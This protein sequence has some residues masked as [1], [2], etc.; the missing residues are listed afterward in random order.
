MANT[1]ASDVKFDFGA[2]EQAAVNAY[3]KVFPYWSDVAAA[4][5]CRDHG[6]IGDTDNHFLSSHDRGYRRDVTA[7][8]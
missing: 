7:G 4:A 1:D 2:H 3:L 8:V 6:P 5:A